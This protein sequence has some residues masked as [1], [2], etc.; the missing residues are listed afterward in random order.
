MTPATD[1]HTGLLSFQDALS[2]GVIAP[3]KCLHYDD[4]FV[5]HDD[6]RG[7]PR[8]TYAMIEEGVVKA[9]VV[10]VRV[11]PIAGI[12]C[13]GIGYAVAAHCRN[14]GVGKTSV[15]KSLE[16]FQDGSRRHLKQLYVEAIVSQDNLFSQRISR[17]LLSDSPKPITD[18]LSGTPSLQFVRLFRL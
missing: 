16:E 6:A 10:F 14:S 7:T 1:L 8:L 4:M 17:Q 3:S 9:T 15:R 11:A 18:H 13:F 5:M 2:S 12:P